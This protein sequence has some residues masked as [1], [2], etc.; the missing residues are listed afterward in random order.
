MPPARNPVVEPSSPVVEPVETTL[1]A[2]IRWLSQAVLSTARNHPARNP[3][4]EPRFLR[5]LSLSLVLSLS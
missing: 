2:S 1:P 4:V 3:V 5:W